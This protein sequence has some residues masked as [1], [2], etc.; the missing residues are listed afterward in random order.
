[1]CKERK[2]TSVPIDF[3]RLGSQQIWAS[4]GTHHTIESIAE[5]QDHMML[6]PLEFLEPERNKLSAC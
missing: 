2:Y 3:R 4:L 1:M 5:D 6:G